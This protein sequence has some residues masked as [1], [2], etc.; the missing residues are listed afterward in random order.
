M[1][2]YAL[3]PIVDVPANTPCASEAGGQRIVV[4]NYEG[5][6]YALHDLCP[7]LA[8]PLSRGEFNHSC[9]VCPGH[10]SVFNLETGQPARWVGKSITWPTR[11]SEGRPRS[12]KCHSLLVEDD[13]LF[14]ELQA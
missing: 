11:L 8:M 10:G 14:V 5:K 2:R 3:A 9:I 7:H 12:A 6:F 13:Q 1:P 4:V